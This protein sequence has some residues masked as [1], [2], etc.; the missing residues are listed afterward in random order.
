MYGMDWASGFWVTV[1]VS[2]N[3]PL[4]LLQRDMADRY[5]LFL[6]LKKKQ[7]IVTYT[8]Y[9]IIMVLVSLLG[10]P[11]GA[12]TG[13]LVC[14]LKGNDFEQILF[15]NFDSSRMLFLIFCIKYVLKLFNICV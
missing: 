8:T 2:L 9:K 13:V 14:K 12:S 1:V 6:I 15:F 7:K 11:I 5:R 4:D 3:S 10:F